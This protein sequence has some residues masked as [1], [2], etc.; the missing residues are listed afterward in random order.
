LDRKF[1]DQGGIAGC[2]GGAAVGR[3]SAIA[4]ELAAEEATEEGISMLMAGVTADA[5]HAAHHT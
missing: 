4:R 3:Q 2:E 5:A 1:Q